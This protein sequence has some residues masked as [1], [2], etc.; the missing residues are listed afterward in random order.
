MS[1]WYR[2]T[3]GSDVEGCG[4]GVCGSGVL[5][6]WVYRVGSIPGTPPW[7]R[8]R[9]SL[10]VQPRSPSRACFWGFPGTCLG[11]CPWCPQ[12][13]C[14][15]RA[16]Q[17]RVCGGPCRGLECPGPARTPFRTQYR[18]DSGIYILKLVHN[19]ECHLKSLMRPAIVPVSKRGP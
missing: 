12:A 13:G 4:T 5:G 11:G 6:G 16:E 19:P 2:V 7:A 15:R 1:E 9:R 18:R 17:G 3:A 8:V 10:N 14:S